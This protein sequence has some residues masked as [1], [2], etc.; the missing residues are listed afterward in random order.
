[1]GRTIA[2][3]DI[4]GCANALTALLDAVAPERD[5]TVV[6]LGDYT[7]RGPD[8]RRVIDR[9]IA[10]AG[11]CNLIP[12]LGNHE[13]ALL[14]A[15]RD[16]SSLRRWLTLGGADTLRSYGWISGGP[17]RALTDWIPELHRTFLSGCHDYYE[18]PTHLFVHAG[19]VPDLAMAEQSGL[20]LRWRV[21]DAA[22]AESHYSGK[23]AVVGHTPQRSG[24]VLD[25]G[26]LVCID[27]NCVRGG[28]LTA[29]DVATNQVWQ[30]DRD[31][32]LRTKGVGGPP[33]V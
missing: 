16:T 29:L 32:K 30:V 25:L 31:G 17:R 9:L 12:L 18:T 26:F 15:L 23:V 7:D 24:E 6:T 22:T 21:T 11:Q 2:I 28:W 33:S 5:D 14:D 27:T 1:M 20:A 4:H 8:S 10:L 13:E 3:G 19:Y